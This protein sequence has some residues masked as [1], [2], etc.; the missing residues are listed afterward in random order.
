MDLNKQQAELPDRVGD[1]TDSNEA[2][3]YPS[4]STASSGWY[5]T[6]MEMVADAFG[7]KSPWRNRDDGMKAHKLRAAKRRARRNKLAKE[8]R[9]RNRRK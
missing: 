1:S 7:M 8:S 4:N 5:G 6:P 9:K 3:P 2:P